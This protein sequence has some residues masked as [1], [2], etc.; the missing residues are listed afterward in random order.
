VE[1]ALTKNEM[2]VLPLSLRGG[3]SHSVNIS[4]VVVVTISKPKPWKEN[5]TAICYKRVTEQI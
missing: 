1:V 5:H 4:N 2:E 3:W